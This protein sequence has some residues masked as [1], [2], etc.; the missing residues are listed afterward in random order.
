MSAC[1]T[2]PLFAIYFH[3]IRL[4]EVGRE[5]Q[6]SSCPNPLTK[7]PIK[8]QLPSTMSKM[9]FECLKGGRLHNVLGQNGLVLSH[10]LILEG[11]TCVS[12]TLIASGHVVKEHAALSE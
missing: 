8:S 6:R 1:Q 7:R 11:T 4:V 5:L 3:R 2:I 10:P 12:V 9:A